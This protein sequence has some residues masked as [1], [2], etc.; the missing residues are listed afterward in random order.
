MELLSFIK[1]IN[2]MYF[3]FLFLEQCDICDGKNQNVFNFKNKN[4]IM[5][6]PQKPKKT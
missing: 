6:S 1:I 4:L 5:L 2:K 3:F